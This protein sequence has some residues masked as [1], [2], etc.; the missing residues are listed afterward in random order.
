MSSR[1]V[2]HTTS[3]PSGERDSRERGAILVFSALVIVVL[4][5]FA[6]V[7]V[8]MGMAWSVKRTEQTSA[9]TSVLAA[10]VEFNTDAGTLQSSVDELT[11]LAQTN[12]DRTITD[13]QWSACTDPDKLNITA[14]DLVVLGQITGP[15]TECISFSSGGDEIR[16]RLPDNPLDTF[17]AGVLGINTI[18]VSA[19]ANATIEL[20][21][22]S[23]SPPF[24]LMPGNG[25][26]AEVCLRSSSSGSDMPGLWVGNGTTVGDGDN[27]NLEIPLD[28]DP[29]QPLASEPGYTPDPCDD[30]AF[31]SPSQ[32]FGTLSPWLYTDPDPSSAPNYACSQPGSNVVDY[33]IAEGIDHNLSSFEP[34]WPGPPAPSIVL[35]DGDNTTNCTTLWPNTLDTQSGFTAGIL[36]CG[37]IGRTGGCS[38]GPTLDGLTFAPRLQRPTYF[39]A[40]GAQF[41]GR[42]LENEPLWYFFRLDMAST[43]L[44]QSCKDVIALPGGVA[45][46]DYYDKKKA[47]T[48]CLKDWSPNNDPPL[49]DLRILKSGRFGFIPLIAES[50]L[51]SQVH[52][53]QFVPL[54]FQTLYQSGNKQGSPDLMCWSQAEGA[55][56]NSGWYRHDAGQPFDCGRSNQNVDRLSGIVLD[57]GMLPEDA[58]LPDGEPNN[59]GGEP[60]YSILLSR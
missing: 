30:V 45:D 17:F 25:A 48:D 41:A 27:D 55:T 37:L 29:T 50:A 24:V 42:Y 21:G 28:G 56:G 36:K 2:P 9:D 35:V 40:S 4:L 15:N 49:F 33:G 53:N 52:I 31:S 44:P 34:D 60:V 59:P 13:P 19:A 10:A 14:S 3:T 38:N 12:S 43:S 23:S 46:W 58:C 57:C 11:A 51:A 6:A 54:W 39:S 26:G 47:A 5:G 16:T 8:D 22:G 18:N 20:P 1:A 7:A 32:F